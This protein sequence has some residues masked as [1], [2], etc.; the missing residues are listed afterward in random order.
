ME[1]SE[2]ENQREA[3]KLEMNSDIHKK[4]QKAAK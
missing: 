3:R 2:N 4:V 1:S